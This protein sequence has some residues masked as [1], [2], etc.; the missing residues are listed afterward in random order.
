ML[1][2][3][4]GFAHGF[5]VPRGRAEVHYRLDSPRDVAS[6]RALRWDDPAVGIDWG[7]PPG[8]TPVLSE[9]DARGA[10]LAEILAEL[11]AFAAG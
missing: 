11:D 3:P 10:S 6:E 7:L 2:V 4:A 5:S 9:R 8:V 1:W